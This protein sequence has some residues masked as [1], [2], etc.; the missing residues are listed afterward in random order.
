MKD[1]IETIFSGITKTKRVANAYLFVGGEQEQKMSAAINF[2]KALNCT[3]DNKPCGD[4]VN[5]KKTDNGIH[6]DVIIMGKDK[7]SFKIEQ[8]RQLKELTHF[9]PSEASYK[10]LIINDA[11]TLTTEAANS[12]L[13]ALEE[14]PAGVVFILICNREEGLLPTI[15]SRCQKIIFKEE[16]PKDIP[17]QVQEIYQTLKQNPSNFINNANLVAEFDN[18]E[19]LLNGLFVLFAQEQAARPARVVFSALKNL[20]SRVNKKLVLDWMCLKLWKTN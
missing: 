6:P 1:R 16:G 17:E 15:A 7:S 8:V 18:A 20:K 10:I 13:K 19:D 11:D 9:G 14:P 5:C 3:S 2:A 4:C 12:F